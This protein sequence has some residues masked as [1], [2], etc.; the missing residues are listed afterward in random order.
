MKKEQTSSRLLTVTINPYDDDA[1]RSQVMPCETQLSTER[2]KTSHKN[3]RESR[4][5][6]VVSFA[7][8]PG[9][10]EIMVIYK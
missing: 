2:L 7:V 3:I 10:L 9:L 1:V 5:N 8:Q 4:E 6:T